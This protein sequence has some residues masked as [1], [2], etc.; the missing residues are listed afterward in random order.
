MAT[1][2]EDVDDAAMFDLIDGARLGRKARDDFAIARVAVREDFDRGALADQRMRCAEHAAETAL[3]DLGVDDVLADLRACRKI[4]FGRFVLGQ[5]LH[6]H[7]FCE[8]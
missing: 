3:A 8:Q 7:P 5:R 4:G 6:Q 2:R 1:E